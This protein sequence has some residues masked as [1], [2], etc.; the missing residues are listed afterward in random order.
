MNDEDTIK[1]VFDLWMKSQGPQGSVLDDD[2]VEGISVYYDEE[3]DEYEFDWDVEWTRDPDGH[4]AIAVRLMEAL[5]E[6]DLDSYIILKDPIIA[7]WW[8]EILKF[9]KAKEDKRI[10]QEADD[11]A[12]AELLSRLTADEKRLLGIK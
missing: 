6:N 12:R 5:V 3:E 11:R 8:G 2:E 9:R 7:D 1:K 4:E 10:K